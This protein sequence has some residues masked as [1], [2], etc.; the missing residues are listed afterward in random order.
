MED[1]QTKQQIADRI[2]TARFL[3]QIDPETAQWTQNQN[4]PT[5]KE[6]ANIASLFWNNKINK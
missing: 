1:C 4:P 5:S 3:A 2:V 6:G